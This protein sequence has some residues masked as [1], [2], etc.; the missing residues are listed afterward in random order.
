MP[1]AQTLPLLL[2]Q[3]RLPT[4]ATCWPQ[5]ETRAR[6]ENWSLPQTL[7]ACLLYTSPSPRD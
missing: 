7:A 4:M 1:D 2:R 6:A 5:L 3:L